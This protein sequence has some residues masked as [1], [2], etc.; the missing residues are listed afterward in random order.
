MS[1]GF[2]P[3]DSVI[4]IPAFMPSEFR[5]ALARSGTILKAWP[6]TVAR[7]RERYGDREAEFRE[8]YGYGFDSLT[9]REA[10]EYARAR[11]ET[12]HRIIAGGVARGVREHSE[13]D[14]RGKA[15][16]QSLGN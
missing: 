3:T 10:A 7:L 4:V 13:N 14:R 6:E 2:R 12:I 9:E 5:L 11:D 1:P 16:R 15:G 8:S